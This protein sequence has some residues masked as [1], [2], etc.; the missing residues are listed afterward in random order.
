MGKIKEGILG[1]FS[2]KVGTVV[3]VLFRDLNVMRA[4]ARPRTKPASKAE[5]LQQAKFGMVS[6]FLQPLRDF[7][8]IG[9]RS[10]ASKG[11]DGANA[12]QSYNQKNAVVV[13]DDDVAVV[14]AEALVSRGDLP[15]I[16]E[17]IA[18]SFEK[19]RVHF[20]WKNN[21][22]L[23]K[24]ADADKAIFVVLC[25]AKHSSIYTLEGGYRRDG[26]GSIAVDAFSGSEVQTWIAFLS[27]DGKDIATSLFTGQLIVA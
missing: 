26:E 12:A 2:G 20:T 23:G 7:L 25:H 19:G 14:C 8:V 9:F 22:G 11:K 6:S 27:K 10:Y 4:L 24:A 16:K 5:L 17:A 1:G 15:N 3:G 21:A 13:Q 18:S